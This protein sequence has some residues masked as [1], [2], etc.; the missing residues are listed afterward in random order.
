VNR[1]RI[2][3]K[4][5]VIDHIVQ[6]IVTDTH[7]KVTEAQSYA[8]QNKDCIENELQLLIG[9]QDEIRRLA[10]KI[11]PEGIQVN[12][13]FY[14]RISNA[15]F[16]LGRENLSCRVLGNV[17]GEACQR[18]SNPECETLLQILPSCSYEIFSVLPLLP[19]FLSRTV[20]REEFAASWFISLGSKIAND[21]ANGPFFEG[22]HEFAM[23]FPNKALQVLEIYKRDKFD[24]FRVSIATAVLAAI[25]TCVDKGAIAQSS[26]KDVADDLRGHPN[27]SYRHAYNLSWIAYFRGGTVSVD[28]LINALSEMVEWTAEDVDDAFWVLSRCISSK[29]QD[30]QF[31]IKAF[32]WIKG[33]TNPSLPKGAKYALVDL[34]YQLRDI[35]KSGSGVSITEMNELLLAIQPLTKDDKGALNLLQLYLAVLLNNDKEVFRKFLGELVVRSPEL[36]PEAIRAHESSYLLNRL[37][38]DYGCSL[39]TELLLSEQVSERRLGRALLENVKVEKLDEAVLKAKGSVKALRVL[40]FEIARRPFSAD[41]TSRIFLLL[42]PFYETTD[43]TLREEF[44]NEMIFQAINFPGACYQAWKDHSSPTPALVE[45]LQQVKTYFDGLDSLR[46]CSGGYITF[47]EWSS[48]LKEW[49]RRFSNEVSEGAKKASIFASL[50]RHIELIYGSEWSIAGTSSVSDPTPMTTF[51]HGMEVPRIE[52]LDPEGCALRRL[53]FNS[54]LRGLQGGDSPDSIKHE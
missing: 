31:L 3:M 13:Q 39:I 38:G 8:E 50:V 22:V 23:H 15:A 40:L 42:L 41:L 16:C 44:V 19:E 37:S 29:K 51:S 48:A 12:K 34:A 35:L 33:K 5:E 24:S 1:S 9:N 28:V 49:E 46:S 53:R 17:F 20:L 6:L 43:A 21:L 47:P 14:T 52:I 18:L 26:V 30:E 10:D 54:L 11:F 27:I 2:A 36:L 4:T 7:E 45:I 25:R 32:K